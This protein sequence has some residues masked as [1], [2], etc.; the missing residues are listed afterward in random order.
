MHFASLLWYDFAEIRS[1]DEFW[2]GLAQALR[3]RGLDDVPGE[4]DR[5]LPHEDQWRS[6]RLLFSQA[7]GYDVVLGFREQLRLV[8]TPLYA[9]P[10]CRG[11]EHCSFVIVH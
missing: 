3:A 8:A 1:T 7:R 10:G 5:A 4:L 2:R 9:A 11:C 6:P